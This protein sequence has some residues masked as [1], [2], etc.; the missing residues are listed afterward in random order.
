[1]FGLVMGWA[2]V[3]VVGVKLSHEVVNVIWT[4]IVETCM[5]SIL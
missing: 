2:I 5:V 4:F 1:M 3:W